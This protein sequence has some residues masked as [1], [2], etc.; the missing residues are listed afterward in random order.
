MTPAHRSHR[1]PTPPFSLS[2]GFSIRETSSQGFGAVRWLNDSTYTVVEPG[3]GGKGT[4]LVQV[5]AASGRQSTLVPVSA[6]ILAG[7][8]DTVEIEDYEWSGDHSR[9]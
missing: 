3:P 2:S 9:L 4:E 5:D 6:L 1:V 7:G 8:R